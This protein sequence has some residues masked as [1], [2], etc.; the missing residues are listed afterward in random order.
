MIEKQYR[1]VSSTGMA[2]PAGVLVSV[3]NE[4]ASSLILEYEGR[5]IEINASPESMMEVMSMGIKP[6]S[7]FQ[8]RVEGADEQKAFQSIEEYFSRMNI[9]H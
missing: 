6:S 3:S 9:V 5:S 4:Y 2:R 7:R 8:L 1:V